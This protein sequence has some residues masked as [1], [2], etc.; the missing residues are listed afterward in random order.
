MIGSADDDNRATWRSAFVESIELVKS[1]YEKV[2]AGDIP[3]VVK[4]FAPD[5]EWRLAEGHPYDPEGSALIG[6][7]SIAK[8]FFTRAGEEWDGFA[9]KPE[10]FHDAGEVVV[11]ECRYGGLYKPTGRTQRTQVC[12]IWRVS[13]GKIAR[14]QQY[15]DT[16][17]LQDV[18]GVR[19][20][21]DADEG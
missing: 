17:H 5:G 9:I 6:P 2:N 11:V 4:S 13:D 12:H 18:M 14:F 8:D 3:G 1:V 16:A 19:S 15:G 20:S 10:R 7:E 21:T